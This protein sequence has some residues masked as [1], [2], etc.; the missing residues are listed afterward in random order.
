MSRFCDKC[1][2]LRSGHL[3]VD[4]IC[5]KCRE[6][7]CPHCGGP[8]KKAPALRGMVKCQGAMDCQF[9]GLESEFEVIS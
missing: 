1:G 9:M 6:Y 2:I 3:V 8:A 4:G 5:D 7:R